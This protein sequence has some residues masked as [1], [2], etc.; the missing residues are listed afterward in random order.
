MN[1]LVVSLEQVQRFEEKLNS[2]RG[3]QLSVPVLAGV[4]SLV[5]TTS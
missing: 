3:K 2:C 4:T 5:G 1:S